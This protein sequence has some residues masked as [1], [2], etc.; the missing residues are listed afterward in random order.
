MNEIE[1]ISIPNVAIKNIQQKVTSSDLETTGVAI[2]WTIGV[3][4]VVFYSIFVTKI[5]SPRYS[6][7]ISYCQS[8]F[9]PGVN[10]ADNLMLFDMYSTKT[11]QHGCFWA[12]LFDHVNKQDRHNLFGTVSKRES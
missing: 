3:F 10:Y 6:C 1:K 8:L 9:A 12:F 5:E 4:V 2:Q 11:I 7:S